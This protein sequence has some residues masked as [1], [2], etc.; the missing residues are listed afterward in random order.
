MQF[1]VPL[2]PGKFH[3]LV[4]VPLKEQV[5]TGQWNT[6]RLATNLDETVLVSYK[7]TLSVFITTIQN[8]QK[9]EEVL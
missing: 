8:F 3:V 1:R 5:E 9:T 4:L 7:R 2:G 6:P